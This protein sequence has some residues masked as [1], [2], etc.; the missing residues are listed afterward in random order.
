MLYGIALIILGLMAAPSL[1]ANKP[2]AKALI[3]K[4]TP[5]QGWIGVVAVL[6]GIYDIIYSVQ[7]ISWL[8]DGIF[9]L[10]AWIVLL[11]MGIIEIGL[12]FIMG[13]SLINEFVLSKNPQAEAKGKEL[14]AKLLP[15]QG[16]IGLGGVAVGIAYIVLLFLA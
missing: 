15:L 14:L 13:F 6:W 10:I 3:D 7:T 8:G 9:W 4:L 1:L 12:G 5:F 11:A 2:E 16:K